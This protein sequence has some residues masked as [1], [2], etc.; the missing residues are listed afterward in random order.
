MTVATFNMVI[1]G[2]GGNRSVQKQSAYGSGT[3]VVKIAAIQGAAAYRSGEAIRDEQQARTYDYSERDD[4][5]RTGMMLP[6]N[7]PE[8]A[9]D[10]ERY[11]NEVDR[12]ETHPRAQLARSIII[13]LPR[14]L[15]LDQNEALLRDFIQQE[16]VDKG[17]VT[18]YAIHLGKSS[19]NDARGNPHAHVLVSMRGFNADG[20]W[21]KQKARELNGY[22]ESRT[23]DRDGNFIPVHQR[24]FSMDDWRD[25]WGRLQNDHLATAGSDATV[26]MHSYARQGIDQIPTIHMGYEATLLENRGIRTAVGDKNRAIVAENARRATLQQEKDEAEVATQDATHEAQR[27][28]DASR[29]A[30]SARDKGATSSEQTARATTPADGAWER[31]KD[32]AARWQQAWERQA[33]RWRDGYKRFASKAALEKFKTFW[34][35]KDTPAPETAQKDEY[36]QKPRHLWS[37]EQKEDYRRMHPYLQA[38][39][40][41]SR[42]ERARAIAV[43]LQYAERKR[44]LERQEMMRRIAEQRDQY[45]Y[46]SIVQDRPLPNRERK[47]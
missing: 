11:W 10:R 29:E 13:G 28:P 2:R 35:F 22:D 27:Q 6:E 32:S 42:R 47:R 12:R 9:N 43:S 30:T 34:Q 4:V 31:L 45:R 26:N 3:K 40:D 46:R 44:A 25:A 16:F 41:L 19:D 17:V 20:T 7:A 39:E 15:D 5:Q 24:F 37:Q 33:E 21:K 1:L 8:Y 23:H 14:E 18:D 38:Q 36:R